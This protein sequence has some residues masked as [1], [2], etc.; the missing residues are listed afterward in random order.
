MIK[1]GVPI[2]IARSARGDADEDFGRLPR[3]VSMPAVL[4]LSLGLWVLI[5]KAAATLLALLS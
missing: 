1:H 3:C 2:E 5:Y 4:F